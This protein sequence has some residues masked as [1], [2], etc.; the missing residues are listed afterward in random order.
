LNEIV[1][2]PVFLNKYGEEGNTFVFE[3]VC[4]N[5]LHQH[6]TGPLI[7]SILQLWRQYIFWVLHEVAAV[8][9]KWTRKCIVFDHRRIAKNL[10]FATNETELK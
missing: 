3:K 1:E 8:R 6:H 4:L 10:F 5:L 2:H 7:L 9:E